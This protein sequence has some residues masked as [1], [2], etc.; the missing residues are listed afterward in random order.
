MLYDTMPNET[1]YP[2]VPLGATLRPT[3]YVPTRQPT[4][5][6]DYS[7]PVSRE[8]V[9]LYV[10]VGIWAYVT[11]LFISKLDAHNNRY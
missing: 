1:T 9:I 5:P 8:Y 10:V 2:P 11:I 6:V 3:V 7:L 4:L